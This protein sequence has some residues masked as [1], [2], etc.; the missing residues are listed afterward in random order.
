MLDLWLSLHWP[1]TGKLVQNHITAWPEK[2]KL[3][4][5]VL[6]QTCAGTLSADG[7]CVFQTQPPKLSLCMPHGIH[8]VMSWNSRP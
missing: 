5:C 6:Q 4:Q 3:H 7:S 2:K 8:A 1:V